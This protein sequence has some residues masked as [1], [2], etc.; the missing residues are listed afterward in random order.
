[1]VGLFDVPVLH[2]TYALLGGREGCREHWIEHE[3]GAATYPGAI[4]DGGPTSRLARQLKRERCLPV[5]CPGP[6]VAAMPPAQSVRSTD[7]QVPARLREE[8]DARL[9]MSRGKAPYASGSMASR[10]SSF[11]ASVS[12]SAVNFGSTLFPP[13]SE[14]AIVTE[15]LRYVWDLETRPRRVRSRLIDR[16][17]RMPYGL[18]VPEVQAD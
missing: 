1:L 9:R 13:F 17:E 4:G 10:R 12:T 16:G 15:F 6:T 7:V 11:G 8:V 14:L 3:T 2:L 18:F 5:R